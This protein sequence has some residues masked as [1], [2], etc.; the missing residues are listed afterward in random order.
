MNRRIRAI[1]AALTRDEKII[2]F[3]SLVTFVGAIVAAVAFQHPKTLLTGLMPA[4]LVATVVYQ[5][6]ARLG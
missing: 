5:A 1:V 2:F 4:G 3:G 6:R